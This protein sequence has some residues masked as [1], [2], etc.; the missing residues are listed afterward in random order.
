MF[1]KK[2]IIG[3]AVGIRNNNQQVLFK[4]I[5]FQY[6][7]TG[8]QQNGGFTSILQG[9]SFDT[10]GLGADI[11]GAG[12]YGSLVVLD[13]SS[14]NSGPVVKFH[15]SSNDSGPRNN[16]VVIENLS[17]SGTNPIAIDANGNTKLANSPT[18]D[19]WIFGNI[20]PGG[21]QAG[22]SSR[23]SRPASL[24]G[25][26]GKYFT[27]PQPTYKEYAADQFVNVKAVPGFP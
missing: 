23:T 21:Y 10:C 6:C 22:Q 4:G 5:S 14:V 17:V 11:T 18:V 2:A 1:K 19:T 9:A 3:G 24:L 26:N 7:T 16:Q 27:A 13:S 15:D 25:A 8:L 12:S 20:A